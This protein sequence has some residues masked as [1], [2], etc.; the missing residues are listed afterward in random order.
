MISG[1]Q[2]LVSPSVEVV[3]ERTLLLAILWVCSTTESLISC[4]TPVA[5]H[6]SPLGLPLGTQIKRAIIDF[7]LELCLLAPGS[8]AH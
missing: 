4:L 2:R 6:L 1:Y 3:W 5:G 8:A 7:L